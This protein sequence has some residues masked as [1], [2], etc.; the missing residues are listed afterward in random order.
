MGDC[1]GIS[2][3]TRSTVPSVSANGAGGA[4]N[5]NY[6][7]KGPNAP[8]SD[9]KE[10]ENNSFHWSSTG[11][12]IDF[13]EPASVNAVSPVGRA[14]PGSIEPAG[15]VWRHSFGSKEIDWRCGYDLVLGSNFILAH[16]IPRSI[17]GLLNG[18][19]IRFVGRCLCPGGHRRSRQIGRSVHHVGCRAGCRPG[20]HG[21]LIHKSSNNRR[22]SNSR[23]ATNAKG[24][25]IAGPL[26]YRSSLI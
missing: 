13:P 7:S 22:R 21:A 20:N 3:D 17:V 23:N 9:R 11:L 14:L 26:L 10:L 24:P 8:P 2:F 19:S 25:I 5:Y 15:L 12:H 6:A 4:E 1:G 18:R 16:S